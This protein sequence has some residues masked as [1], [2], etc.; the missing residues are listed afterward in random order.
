M[1][2]THRPYCCESD[3]FTRMCRFAVEDTHARG[4]RYVWHLGR[5]TDWKYNLH[6]LAKLMPDNFTREAELWHDAFGD[7]CGMV[8]SEYFGPELTLMVRRG[9][10]HLAPE[11][12]VFAQAHWGGRNEALSFMMPE[13]ETALEAALE[14]AGFVLQ[15]DLEITYIFET[16][17]YAD[18]VP[19]IPKGFSFTSMAG[20]DD[21]ASHD[22]MRRSAFKPALDFVID[23]LR[24]E[25]TRRSPIYTPQTDFVLIDATGRHVSG[26]EAF[27]DRWNNNAEIERVCTLD[28]EWGKGYARMALVGCLHNLHEL[29]IPRAFLTGG[30]DKTQHLYGSLGHVATCNRRFYEWRK[31]D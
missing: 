13:G 9:W 6:N 12:L 10:E 17:R 21:Y 20:N 15:E 30:H 26:C 24:R 1:K 18:T 29:G 4:D 23:Q 3:D 22:A 11:M 14:N 19:A 7:L 28:S 16:A 5:M 27:I 25:Y 31:Q 2:T 8:F